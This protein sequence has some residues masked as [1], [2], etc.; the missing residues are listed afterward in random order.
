MHA[1]VLGASVQ[2]TRVDHVEL[3]LRDEPVRVE[4]AR[5]SGAVRYAVPVFGP[6]LQTRPVMASYVPTS[7]PVPD[8]KPRSAPRRDATRRA[9]APRNATL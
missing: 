7:V 1:L 9:A 4:P 8:L 5:L 6:V 2:S 3:E